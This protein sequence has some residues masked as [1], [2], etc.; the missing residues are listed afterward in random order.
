MAASNISPAYVR[1]NVDWY[2]GSGE[3]PY[4]GY[5]DKFMYFHLSKEGAPISTDIRHIFLSFFALSNNREI[6]VSL[7]E[8]NSIPPLQFL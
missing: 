5:M 8:L 2:I 6:N 3:Y 4:S 1:N 7:C